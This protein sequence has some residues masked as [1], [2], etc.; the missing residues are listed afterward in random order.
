[1][2]LTFAVGDL[3]GA[4]DLFERGLVAIARHAAG[5]APGAR[6]VVFLGDYVDRGP[7]SRPILERLMA[8]PPAGWQ[9][10]C[11]KGNHEDM[12]AGALDGTKDVGHWLDNGGDATLRSFGATEVEDGI[13]RADRLPATLVPWLE[14]LPTFATDRHRVFVHA[15]V[16]PRV[17]LEKQSS[18]D[19][20]WLRR[21]N[22]LGHAERY[23][24]HGHT[25]NPDGPVVDG[26]SIN[27][28][29]LAWH[30]GRLVVA[31]F[32]D[33]REGGPIDFIEIRRDASFT[34]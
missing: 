23:V 8:G 19:L 12:M 17:P 3:H 22:R 24:V 18:H 4:D 6:T 2:N 27:L 32:D 26:Q 7:G 14:A 1:M 29:T 28:D 5:A 16:H 10:I 20:L 11:L 33:D 9:W 13:W 31:V 15:S 34:M 21:S 30:T 25:P